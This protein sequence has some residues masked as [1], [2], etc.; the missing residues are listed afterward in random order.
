MSSFNKIFINFPKNPVQT[1]LLNGEIV[2]ICLIM[3]NRLIFNFYRS[4][5]GNGN[6]PRPKL[7]RHQGGIGNN[8]I[9]KSKIDRLS[10]IGG[11]GP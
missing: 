6:S 11:V 4:I 3:S 5:M 7:N 2:W 1:L 9:D 8:I 10:K